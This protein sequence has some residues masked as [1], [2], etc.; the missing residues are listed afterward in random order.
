MNPEVDSLDYKAESSRTARLKRIRYLDIIKLSLP[1]MIGSAVQNLIA[2]TDSIFLG[3]LGQTEFAAIGLVGVFYLTITSIGYSFSKAGQIMIARLVG[4]D[5]LAQIGGIA[6]SMWTFSMLIATALFFF[7]Y[8]LGDWFFGLFLHDEEVLQACLDYLHYR[9]PGIFFSYTGVVLIALY[10]GVARTN[11]IL[12]TSLLLGLANT[13][14]NYSLIFGFWVF[15]PMGMA[16]AALA[17]TLAE[18]LAFVVFVG[19]ILWDKPNRA[20]GLFIWPTIEWTLIKAQLQLSMPIIVQSVVGVG[21]WFVFFL[22]IE[23]MGKEPLAI[24][25]LLR[26]VYLLLMIP[27]WGFASGV[28]TLV[29]NALGRKAVNAILPIVWKTAKL[30]VALTLIFALPLWIVPE[31]VLLIGTDDA[32]I[33]AGA[34]PLL[35]LFGGILVLFCL[36]SIF[37]NG[38]VGTGATR[39]ALILQ[40]SCVALYLAYVFLAIKVFKAGLQAAWFSE[41][42]YWAAT[43]LLTWWYLASRR[44]LGAPPPPSA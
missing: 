44:W 9:A 42:L 34:K 24:S 35:P 36:G 19:Y 17:S 27:C 39:Q 7:M 11:V 3:R 37:F 8:G 16:G 38:L 28:N 26:V 40:V 25:N 30:T 20:Y 43:F 22:I 12:Y 1:I 33:I 23:D 32:Q 31:Y 41:V 10:T 21:S 14:L 13:F 6:Y 4:E 29:S 15:P 2:L 5:K 18:I